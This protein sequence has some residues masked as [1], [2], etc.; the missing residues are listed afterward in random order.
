MQ[1]TVALRE[2]SLR[3]TFAVSKRLSS[4]DI[5]VFL[6]VADQGGISAAAR[7]LGLQKSFVSRELAAFEREVGARLF[8]RTTRRLR[9]TDAG[10][11]LLAYARRAVEELDNAEA[12]LA[13]LGEA[14]RGVLRVTLPYAFLR[15]ILAPHL[16]QFQ[17][18]YPDLRIAFDPNTRNLDLVQEGVDLAI[19]IGDI[20]PTTMVAKLLGHVPMVLVA[21]PAYVKKHGMPARP[22]ELS[23][24]C[25]IESGPSVE[26]KIW[27]LEGDAIAQCE[28][29]VSPRVAVAEPG[30]LLDLAVGG[31]GIAVAPLIYAEPLLA[32]GSLVRILPAFRRGVRPIHVI[33]PSRQLV[34]PKLRIFV[35]FINDCWR[36]TNFSGREI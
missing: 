36:A 5:R 2:Q 1:H 17:A 34:A 31:L 28:I 26:T 32:S 9:L 7:Y 15:I 21:A 8:Q 4:V 11:I 27:T 14:P 33:Y 10:T 18:Q 16:A 13:S 19:R 35:D 22:E 25:L 12:A 29:P 20:A 6:A 30:V 23:D 24:H 3:T